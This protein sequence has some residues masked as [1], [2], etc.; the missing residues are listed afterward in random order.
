AA[1]RLPLQHAA[2]FALAAVGVPLEDAAARLLLEHDL[3]DLVLADRVPL[4]RPPAADLP[5]EDPERL[6][7]IA[8]DED[9][10]VDRVNCGLRAV[11]SLP[12]FFSAAALNPARACSQKLSK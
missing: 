1:G 12:P 5:G 8:L 3:G 11:H 7:G 10:L 2:P 4:E 9:G 6:L